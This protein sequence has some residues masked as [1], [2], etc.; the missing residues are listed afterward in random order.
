[1]VIEDAAGLVAGALDAIAAVSPLLLGLAVALH[2]LKVTAEARAWHR[3]LA[4]AQH[5][6]E[7]PFRTTLAAFVCSIGANAFLPARVGEAFRVGVVRRRVPGSSVATIAA[8]IALESLLELSFA[9]AVLGVLFMGGRSA[10]LGLSA[11]GLASQPLLLG[12]FAALLVFVG[13]VAALFRRWAVDLGRRL[14]RGFAVVGSPRAFGAVCAWK[15]TAW[16]LRIATVLVFLAAFHVHSTPWTPFV[17]I[18]AQSIA[19]VVPVLPGNA[20]TQQAAF[21]VVLAGSA[22]AATILGFGIGMQASTL[23]ADVVV[24][25]AAAALLA[26]SADPRRVLHVL[27]ARRLARATTG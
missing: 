13:A 19:G 23:L 15:L 25:G 18:G 10:P 22:S 1:V 27:R 20:G 16:T 12:A 2:L 24:G 6:S 5:P 7:V 17:V 4:Y 9:A 21:A 14:A 8:T 26:G 11:G 3:I